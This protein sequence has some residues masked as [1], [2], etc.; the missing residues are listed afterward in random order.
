MCLT[1]RSE[2]ARSSSTPSNAPRPSRLA[3]GSQ[4]SVQ[5]AGAAASPH[6]AGGGGA[7]R[8]AGTGEPDGEAPADAD[9][10]AESGATEGD[11][12]GPAADGTVQTPATGA[13]RG[14]PTAPSSAPIETTALAA[15]QTASTGT[16]TRDSRGTRPHPTTIGGMRQAIA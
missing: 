5:P 1:P 15:R 12:A 9:G 6:E 2:P 13:R 16:P 3:C 10:D 4:T 11:P 14:P 8:R 7:P